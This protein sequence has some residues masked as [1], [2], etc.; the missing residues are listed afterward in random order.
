MSYV[1]LLHV[2][3]IM[4]LTEELFM[5]YLFSLYVWY[6]PFVMVVCLWWFEEMYV[7]SPSR[8]SVWPQIVLAKNL[9]KG[10]IVGYLYISLI[11]AKT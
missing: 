8:L 4:L 9:T 6:V 3:M 2:C 11:I 7:W 5:W 10:K 1:I